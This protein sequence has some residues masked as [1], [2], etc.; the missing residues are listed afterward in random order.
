MKKCFID[1]IKKKG[2]SSKPGPGRYERNE[3]FNTGS[4][5]HVMGARMKIEEAAIDRSK[6]LPGPGSY[7]HQ[8]VT[9]EKMKVSNVGNEPK[10]SFG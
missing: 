3:R 9:G 7:E 8:P 6:T 10:F 5:S 4:R 1:D 2:D